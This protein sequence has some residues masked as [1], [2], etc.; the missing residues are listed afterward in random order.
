MSFENDASNPYMIVPSHFPTPTL[1]PIYVSNLLNLHF[2][3]FLV[4]SRAAGRLVLF[5]TEMP[6]T[7][8]GNIKQIL[9]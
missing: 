1:P 4:D 7:K 5:V 8:K 9:P 6:K 3:S 2:Q